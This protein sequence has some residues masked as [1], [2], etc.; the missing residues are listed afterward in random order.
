MPNF[1]SIPNPISQ[2]EKNNRHN[3]AMDILKWTFYMAGLVMVPGLISGPGCRDDA[4]EACSIVRT[5]TLLAA[6]GAIAVV[7]IIG[8]YESELDSVQVT[9]GH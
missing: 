8:K 5:L 9:R 2:S 7:G 1:F 4:A 6:A 3:A